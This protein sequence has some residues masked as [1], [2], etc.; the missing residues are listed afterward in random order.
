MDRPQQHN[1][2]CSL[3][4]FIDFLD[5]FQPRLHGRYDGPN[6]YLFK[7]SADRLLSPG[8]AARYDEDLVF[9]L[10]QARAVWLGGRVREPLSLETIESLDDHLESRGRAVAVTLNLDQHGLCNGFCDGADTSLG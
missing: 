7:K 9:V 1:G 3:R 4:I 5:G 6:A 10:I 2:E 8:I